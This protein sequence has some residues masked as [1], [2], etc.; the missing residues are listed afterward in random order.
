MYTE[1]LID[2]FMN[3][4]NVGVLE[5]ADGSATIGDP[6]CGD[7]LCMYIR[8]EEMHIT[9]IAFQCKGCPASIASASAT[10]E[11]AKGKHI[12]DA[13]L[14]NPSDVAG[15]LGGMPEQ[16]LHCSNLGVMA[17]WH[18]MADYL[19]LLKDDDSQF[20]SR[21]EMPETIQE[22]P[23]NQTLEAEQ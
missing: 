17:L 11:M 4:R 22:S 10:T 19:G 9:E 12:Q 21:W 16:K 18:A 20:L 13:I 6:S 3:P 23:D 14:I 5:D 15:Y 8:V 1:R 7:F 2:H